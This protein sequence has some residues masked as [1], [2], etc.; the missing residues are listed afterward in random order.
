MVTE[1]GIIGLK[2]GLAT[3][4]ATKCSYRACTDIT[5]GAAPGYCTAYFSDCQNFGDKCILTQSCDGYTLSGTTDAEKVVFCSKVLGTF[6]VRC[7]Y[8]SGDSACSTA[9]EDCSTY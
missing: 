7:T 8:K 6:S 2:C 1:P 9:E 4:D 3:P 5:S